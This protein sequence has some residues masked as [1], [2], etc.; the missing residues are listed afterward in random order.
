MAEVKEIK[1]YADFKKA[2]G[3]S[4]YKTVKTFKDNQPVLYDEYNSKLQHE[5][6]K[7]EITF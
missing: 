2:V 4:Q 1:D 5:H 7:K 6:D 3:K